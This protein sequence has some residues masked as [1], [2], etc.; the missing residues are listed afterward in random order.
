MP[1]RKWV[2]VET[3]AVLVPLVASA[4]ISELFVLNPVPTPLEPNEPSI[5]VVRGGVY[6]DAPHAVEYVPP[7]P[8]Q[9]PAVSPR[10]AVAVGDK[11]NSIADGGP[12]VRRTGLEG[13]VDRVLAAVNEAYELHSPGGGIYMGT[14]QVDAFGP[15]PATRILVI[16]P[17]ETFRDTSSEWDEFE[18]LI[19][20]GSAEGGQAL[21]GGIWLSTENYR[22]RNRALFSFDVPS[23][24]W[25]YSAPDLDTS[26]SRLDRIAKKLRS[27]MIGAQ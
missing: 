5:R 18:L 1:R 8:I 12:F 15:F 11:P 22:R 2:R 21:G 10:G 24:D 16:V 26:S 27:L 23:P 17:S 13:A 3:A 20:T 9:P 4:I 14:S 6:V 25:E 7:A 19:S